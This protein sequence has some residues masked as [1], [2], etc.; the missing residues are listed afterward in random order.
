MSADGWGRTAEHGGH[1]FTVALSHRRF[2]QKFSP[3]T[4]YNLN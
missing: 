1:P 2:T 4:I 3:F